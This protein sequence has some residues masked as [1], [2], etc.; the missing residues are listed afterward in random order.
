MYSTDRW[1][2]FPKFEETAL[3][4]KSRLE[5]SGLTDVEIDGAS[6]DG[7]TQAGFWTMPLAWDVKAARLEVTSPERIV[8]CDYE[9][10]PTCLGMWSGPT[11]AGGIDAELVDLRLTPPGSRCSGKIVLTDKNPASLKYEL[12]EVQGDLGAVNAFT[13][14]PELLDGRQWINAW[15]DSGWGYT[16]TST[17]LLCYSITPRQ[18]QSLRKDPCEGKKITL[19]AVVGYALLRRAIPLCNWGSAREQIVARRFS[20]SVTHPSRAPRIMQRE[21]PRTSKRSPL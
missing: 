2:T 5:E 15:G 4:L 19:H 12:V 7:H 13:E 17:P 9:K 20:F 16:K 18:A 21:L 14:N 3:Y 1:F 11:P 6:A 10:V 8:L